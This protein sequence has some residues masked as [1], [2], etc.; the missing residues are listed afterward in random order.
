MAAHKISLTYDEAADTLTVH[1]RTCVAIGQ[2][3]VSHEEPVELADPAA[4]TATLK[5]WIDTNRAEM[6]KT[7]QLLA[8][9]HLAAI[10]GKEEPGVKRIKLGGTLGAAGDGEVKKG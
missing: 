2:I 5:D 1:H 9:R 7:A 4:V 8:V 10:E 6:D 3:V